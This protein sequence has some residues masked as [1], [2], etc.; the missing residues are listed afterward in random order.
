MNNNSN[1]SLQRRLF[2]GRKQREQ[3]LKKLMLSDG[4]RRVL[5]LLGARMQFEFYSVD[6]V[7]HNLSFSLLTAK[8]AIFRETAKLSPENLQKRKGN[9]H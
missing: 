5:V 4:D 3:I 6:L 1:A 2:L 7:K 8:V 9:G